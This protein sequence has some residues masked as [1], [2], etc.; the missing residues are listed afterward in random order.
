MSKQ[1]SRE[2]GTRMFVAIVPADDV[3][4]HLDAHLGPRREHA[5]CILSPG[6]IVPDAS[7]ADASS[8]DA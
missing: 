6:V 8:A 7:S 3:F 1:C 4:E 2:S 5:A